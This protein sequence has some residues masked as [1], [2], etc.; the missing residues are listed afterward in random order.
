MEPMSHA[1]HLVSFSGAELGCNPVAVRT[2]TSATVATCPA[3][4]NPRQVAEPHRRD[5]EV[6][7]IE[8]GEVLDDDECDRAG[9]AQ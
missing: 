5:G 6:E 3:G 1:V 8:Q 4:L 2:T 7:R 9:D